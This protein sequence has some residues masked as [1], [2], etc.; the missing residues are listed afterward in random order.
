MIVFS[1]D[2]AVHP[3]VLGRFDTFV[4]LII[5]FPGSNIQP[6]FTAMKHD[7]SRPLPQT[8]EVTYVLR[9]ELLEIS[10][11]FL[12]VGLVDEEDAARE[13]AA[14]SSIWKHFVESIRRSRCQ[15]DHV[16]V[17]HGELTMLERVPRERRRGI[18][19]LS[20]GIDKLIALLISGQEDRQLV[21]LDKSRLLL[22]ICWYHVSVNELLG[23]CFSIDN[24]DVCYIAECTIGDGDAR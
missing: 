6:K 5:D 13:A 17:T 10:A 20:Q 22:C 15:D 16:D 18:E 24:S 19:E 1:T 23:R 9:G 2:E 8:L 12:G 11:R 14:K 4:P 7:I 3:F 21:R